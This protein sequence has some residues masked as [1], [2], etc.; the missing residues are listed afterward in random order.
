LATYW[1]KLEDAQ[2]DADRA[3]TDGETAATELATA[4]S[5]LETAVSELEDA[6]EAAEDPDEDEVRGGVREALRTATSAHEGAEAAVVSAESALTAAKALA[7]QAKEARE[8]A[9]EICA[10][11]LEEASEAGI[12]NKKWWQKA[13]DWV[14]DNWDTI[15]AIAKVVVAVLGIVVM[16]IGGPLAW[17]VL[18]AALIVLADTLIDYANGNASLWD[19]G[20]ATLDCIPGFKGLTTAG[21]LV[22]MARKGLDDVADGVRHMDKPFRG[23]AA[24][25]GGQVPYRSLT[26]K[27]KQ[28]VKALEANRHIPVRKGEVNI[29]HLAEI[30]RFSGVEH[31]VIQNPA[32]QLR[33]FR[34]TE[35]T[36]AIP[37]DLRGQG[38][39]FIAH[40][41]PEDRIPGPARGSAEE[42][43]GV[44]NSMQRDLDNKTSSH[45]EVVIS[46]NDAHT[47]FTGD[48]ILDL[49]QGT[50]PPGG[51]VN[52]RGFIVP[53][54]RLG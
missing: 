49:P 25:P 6:E 7:G 33:L 36:S 45:V 52:D 50:Y 53:V 42:A 27:A 20:F 1:P 17:V 35:T 21:G 31:A 9:A 15:V 24:K 28:L 11:S 23:N 37:R 40:T 30:Q 32:G 12:Q 22:L 14:V 4:R 46:R 41:H 38:Y 16:I 19:V 2:R 26:P 44:R 51:P 18:A 47:F 43:M 10:A 39:D 29:S 13:V 3:L 54:P 5:A 34:G 48:S 8:T